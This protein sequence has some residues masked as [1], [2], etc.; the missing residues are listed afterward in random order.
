MQTYPRIGILCIG[1]LVSSCSV[2]VKVSAPPPPY[3]IC[4]PAEDPILTGCKKEQPTSAITIRG[5]HE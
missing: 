3:K 5:H 2:S 1:L 4:A